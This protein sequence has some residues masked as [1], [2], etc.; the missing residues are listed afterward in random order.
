MKCEI[1]GGEHR[2]NRLLACHVSRSHSSIISKEEYTLKY[3]YDNIHPRCKCGCGEKTS[4]R[5]FGKFMIYISGHNTRTRKGSAFITNF[6]KKELSEIYHRR[7]KN[8]VWNNPT[9]T[10]IYK[11][12]LFCNKKFRVIPASF[13]VKRFC[14]NNC[15]YRYKVNAIKN[16]TLD[17]IKYLNDCSKGGILSH[18]GWKNSK[19]ELK[20]K[21]ILNQNNIK[22]IH[23]YQIKL[24]NGK[25]A[26]VDF[27]IDNNIVLQVD[28]NYWHCNP[29][30]FNAEYYHTKIKKFA[31]DIWKKDKLENKELTKRGFIVKRI[32]EDKISENNILTLIK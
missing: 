16:K 12:C 5:Y 10:Y 20:V 1:C 13:D 14:S 11:N 32:W 17:G 8:G 31:K 6:N 24:D 30:K 27:L 4:Y 23:Q 26:M 7:Y 19:P 28:G 3:L 18:P 9:K 29:E 25:H 2:N 15:Y 22:F 21:S